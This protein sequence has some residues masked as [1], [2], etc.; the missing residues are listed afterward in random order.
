MSIYCGM[1]EAGR[2]PVIGPMVIASVVSDDETMKKAGAKDSKQLTPGRRE[3]IFERIKNEA[4]EIKYV[5]INSSEI[6]SFMKKNNLNELEF[7]KYKELIEII[8]CDHF[9]IDSFDVSEE[10]LSTQLSDLTG[11]KVSCF[12]R[13]DK[14]FP[15]VSAA[16][17]VAKHYRE[18]EM[19]KIRRKY[20]DCGSGYPSDPKTIEFL[21]DNVNNER[22]VDEIVRREWITF[23]RM[24]K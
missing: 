1:D 2:G 8:D 7:K 21:R 5:I 4:I 9:V 20:G 18:S 19:E 24:R 11:K 17:I 12:H 3:Y 10:R 23:K 16:S 6:N 14:N 22:L 15:V 13:A